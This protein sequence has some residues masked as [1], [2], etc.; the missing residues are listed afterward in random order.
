MIR[1]FNK[2]LQ[3]VLSAALIVTGLFL[4]MAGANAQESMQ[5]ALSGIIGRISSLLTIGGNKELSAE[6]KQQEDLQARKDAVSRIFDLTLM[7]QSDLRA[8]L[9]GL[10]N[11]AA[12]Q[13]KTRNSL[14][15]Q[16]A[17]NENSFSQIRD[18]LGAAASAEDVK[19]L[20][21]DFKN[22]RTLVYDLKVKKIVPFT[23]VFQEESVLAI[24][25]QRLEKISKDFNGRKDSLGENKI[26]AT[27]LFEKASSAIKNAEDLHTQAKILIMVALTDS[28]APLSSKSAAQKINDELARDITDSKTFTENSLQDTSDA[29]AAFIALGQLLK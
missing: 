9:A 11:L 4:P 10:K 28:P 2:K 15:D 26:Q 12:A 21:A 29:Y 13:E 22:W 24:A 23:F 16:L 25:Q 7:E 3:A 27:A 19:Q 20:A 17:E 8:R 6:E 1:R 5:S 18:R 14:M